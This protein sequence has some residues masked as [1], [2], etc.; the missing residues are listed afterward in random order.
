MQCL[1]Q[2]V[3]CPRAC[4]KKQAAGQA[5]PRLQ[6]RGDLGIRPCAAEQEALPFVAAFGTQATQLR[7]GFDAFRNDIHAK[8]TAKRDDGLDNSQRPLAFM[9]GP[10][11]QSFYGPLIG[12]LG[13]G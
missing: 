11:D 5:H 1:Q 2:Q 12:F 9:N 4:A 10:E 7:F 13:V 8:T 3:L 6:Q